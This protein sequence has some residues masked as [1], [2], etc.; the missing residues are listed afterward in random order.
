MENDATKNYMT[1]TTQHSDKKGKHKMSIN[2]KL[3]SSLKRMEIM[4]K[5][6]LKK[7]REGLDEPR[8]G[9]LANFKT[10]KRESN[11]KSRSL[12]LERKPNPRTSNRLS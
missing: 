4:T 3:E 8:S 11:W 10:G 6:L 5:N 1:D 9:P 7:G 12:L 2:D